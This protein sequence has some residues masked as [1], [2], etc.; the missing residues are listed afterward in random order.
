MGLNKIEEMRKEEIIMHQREMEIE[1]NKQFTYTVE[2]DQPRKIDI[3]GQ[4]IYTTTCLKCNFTCHFKCKYADDEDK[5][6]C[7]AMDSSQFCKV[8]PGHCYWREH[9]NLPYLIQFETVV[10]T[11]TSE[12]LKKKYE[13]AQKGKLKVSDMLTTLDQFLQNV[14]TS[15]MTK[16]YKAQEC[17]RR[18]DII[19]L[20]PNPLSSVD[21]LQLLIESEK[22]SAKPGWQQR[23]Q[24]YEEAKRCAEVLSKVKDVKTAQKEIKGT[25]LSG[26]KWYSRFKFW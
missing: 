2:V 9:K 12:D 3:S 21:H 4:G 23:I 17:L 14:H 1:T 10:E 24:Y 11:R 7:S 22:Q 15:V 13:T 19:A 25:K 20:K 8:C 16:I 5:Y 6:R 18:L 26:D